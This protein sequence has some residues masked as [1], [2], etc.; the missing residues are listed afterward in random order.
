MAWR[1]GLRHGSSEMPE[2]CVVGGV[3]LSCSP[4][5]RARSWANTSGVVPLAGPLLD[6]SLEASHGHCP[7]QLVAWSPAGSKKADVST[8]VR[9]LKALGWAI[10]VRFRLQDGARTPAPCSRHPGSDCRHRR[11]V[12]HPA[13][14]L[15]LA[16]R[17]QP[18]APPPC[19]GG[20]VP[21]GRLLA[22]H[23]KQTLSLGVGL[24]GDSLATIGHVSKH[25]PRSIACVQV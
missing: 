22:S 12:I 7:P 20:G 11:G 14:M 2:N 5:R 21:A 18:S 3:A 17:I 23:A 10:C 19:A 6:D 13:T 4:I 1:P 25:G 15:Q 24:I 9:A 8:R 16:R